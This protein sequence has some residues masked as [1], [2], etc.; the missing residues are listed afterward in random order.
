M[1]RWPLVALAAVLVCAL[2]A[3]AVVLVRVAAPSGSVRPVAASGQPSAPPDGPPSPGA[4]GA[5]DEYF[6]KLGNGGYDVRHYAL[7]V[8]YDPSTDVLTGRATIDAAATQ[9]MSQFNLDFSG[10][11]ITALRAGG[12]DATWRLD[13]GR[14]LVVTPAVPL[15]AGQEFTIE[16]EYEGKPDGD[17]FHHTTDGAL[18][19]GEPASGADWYPTNEHPTDKATYDFEI[20]VPDGLTAIANGVSRGVDAADPGWRT[21]RWAA[22]TPMASYLSTIAIG[23]FR[24]F[25]GTYDGRPVYSAVDERLP[26]GGV[27]D[28]AMQRTADVTGFLATR[29]GPYPFEALGGI[30]TSERLSFALETQTRPIYAP[31]FFNRTLSDATS[32]V[33]HEIAHQWFGDSVSLNRWRDIWLNEGFATYAQWLW[34][35]HDGGRSAQAAFD[36]TYGA[37]ATA[38]IWTPPP[39]DPGEKNLFADSVYVRGGLTVHALRMTIGDDAFFRLLPEWTS[40]HKSGT[41]T[42]A[43][44]IALAEKLSGKEL[45]AFFQAW[46]FSSA[47]PPYP[48]R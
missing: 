24:I 7:R 32:I 47:K 41:G 11:K 15:R 25:E 21:W 45:D 13:G 34:E 39:G 19:A 22:T 18:V 35:E 3:G 17:G 14:E 40:A 42:T 31:A 9:S 2:V 48:G 30:V 1:R 10:L 38:E 6:P 43:D 28:Q 20:T 29:F 36:D 27:A 4:D 37:P 16:A 44:F 26:A 5:G 46:L 23:K 33:A 8:R 12:A